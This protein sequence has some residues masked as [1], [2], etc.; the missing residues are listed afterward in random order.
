M[1]AAIVT[2]ALAPASPFAA[3]ASPVSL[4]CC[5]G[6]FQTKRGRSEKS[7]ESNWKKTVCWNTV[8]SLL[9]PLSR[10]RVLRVSQKAAMCIFVGVK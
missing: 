5:S 4:L 2:L 9:V 6:F 7:D 8:P 3:F 10:C 1:N